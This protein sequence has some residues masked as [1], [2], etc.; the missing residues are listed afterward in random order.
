M[1]TRGASALAPL[2]LSACLAM[3]G[4][5]AAAGVLDEARSRGAL[6]LLW[7]RDSEPFSYGGTGGAPAGYAVELCGRV[8]AAIAPGLPVQWRPVAL[9]E[10]VEAVSAGSGDLL[11]GPVTVTLP[12]L[13]RMDFTSPILIGGPGVLLR[14]GAPPVLA[15]W[16]DPSRHLSRSPRGLLLDLAGPKRVAVL[17]GSTGATWLAGRIARDHLAVTVVPVTAHSEAAR[18]LA[19]N[20]AEAWVGEWAVLAEYAGRDEGLASARLLPRPLEGEPLALAMPR[21]DVF[22]LAVEAALVR[23]IRGPDFTA[24][25]ARWLGHGATREAAEIR[26]VTPLE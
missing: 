17:A 4:E 1:R 19:G 16:L 5:A 18:L 10:G 7:V 2:I 15:E 25:L 26:A 21:D 8:A 13:S 6:R 14:E 24:L 20:D 3:A 23:I 9:T 22:G 12:R 11:C